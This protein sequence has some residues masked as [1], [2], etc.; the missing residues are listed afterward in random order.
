MSYGGGGGTYVEASC[1]GRV[2]QAVLG[3]LG[4]RRRAKTK[5][6]ALRVAYPFGRRQGRPYR[7]WCDEVRVQLGLRPPRR[8]Y[9]EPFKDSPGQMLLFEIDSPCNPGAPMAVC[10][11]PLNR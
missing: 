8:R 4:S 7:V 5:R 1:A 2:I 9:L 10:E 6:R 11:Q 3:E